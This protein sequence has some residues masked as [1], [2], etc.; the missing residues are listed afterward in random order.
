MLWTTDGKLFHRIIETITK[1]RLLILKA[2]LC[3]SSFFACRLRKDYRTI[4]MSHQNDHFVLFSR[5]ARLQL[6]LEP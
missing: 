5:F 2:V 3:F 1:G 4:L 6:Y